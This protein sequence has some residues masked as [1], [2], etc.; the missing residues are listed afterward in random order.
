[1]AKPILPDDE[2]ALARRLK[3][4][5]AASRPAF[6]EPLHARICQAVG[7]RRP[8]VVRRPQPRT[9]QS[10]LALAATA[11]VCL[12]GA[13]WIASQWNRP[14]APTPK[15]RNVAAV[16]EPGDPLRELDQLVEMPNVTAENVGTAV[17]AALNT[18]RWAYLDQ[19]AQVAARLLMDKLPLDLLASN[20]E[21]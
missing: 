5:A 17:Q 15:R 13:W 4:E 11:A 10:G 9:W 6:S 7:S 21:P 12:A 1:M 3:R 16:P 20:H 8:S 2:R 14:P 19:D 18:R